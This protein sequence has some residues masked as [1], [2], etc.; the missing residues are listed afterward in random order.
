MPICTL[1][2]SP[3][4]IDTCSDRDAET[5]R[6]EL[7]EGRLM[8]LAMAV[9]AGQNFDSADGIHANFGGFPKANSCSQ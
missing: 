3:C 7:S 4:T 6:N 2:V 5:M 8:T 9:R 1:S